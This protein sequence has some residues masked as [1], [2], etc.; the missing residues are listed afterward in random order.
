MLEIVFLMQRRAVFEGLA[1]HLKVDSKNTLIEHYEVFEVNANEYKDLDVILIEIS[2]TSKY[3]VI[4]CLD[5]VKMIKVYNSNVK[6][7]LMCSEHDEESINLVL[8]A[9]KSKLI[10]DFVFYDVSLDYLAIKLLTV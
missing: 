7:L 1:K 5:L 4:Y 8:H 2:E 10:D 6:I 9:K 3:D